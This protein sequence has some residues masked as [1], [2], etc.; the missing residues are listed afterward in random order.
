MTKKRLSE[1]H[2]RKISLALKGVAI[3]EEHKRKLREAN[4]GKRH[5]EETKKKMSA[6]QI[7]SYLNG[8]VS[9]TLGKK[10]SKEHKQKIRDAN[11]GE[12][13]YSWKGDDV[14]YMGLHYWV[15]KVLG[16]PDICQNCKKSKLSGRKI[17]WANISGNYKRD[18]IDWIRL[19]ASCHKHF[20]LKNING[21][22]NNRNLYA[23]T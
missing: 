6:S 8:R 7:S 19:C 4:L 16:K 2:K 1:E 22:I 3:S 23:N 13:S 14:G 21:Y 17:H 18:I 10:F 12:K 11:S 5:S 15:Y 20:D 9:A